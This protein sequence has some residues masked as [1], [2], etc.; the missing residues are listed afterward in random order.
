M[1]SCLIGVGVEKERW[2]PAKGQEAG[3]AL[4][5]ALSAPT[6]RLETSWVTVGHRTG[7]VEKA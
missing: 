1:N 6:E 4:S 7:E 3:A 5:A 2:E